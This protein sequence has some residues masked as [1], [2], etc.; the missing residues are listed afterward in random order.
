MT[1]DELNP[2]GETRNN[3]NIILALRHS[4]FRHSFVIR[5]STFVISNACQINLLVARFSAQ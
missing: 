2:D 5:H 4:S 3:A 1:N